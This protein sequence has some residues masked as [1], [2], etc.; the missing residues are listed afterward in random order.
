MKDTSN[1]PEIPDEL[2]KIVDNVLA[3]RPKPKRRRQRSASARKQRWRN[4]L[5]ND[6]RNKPIRM[7]RK[8]NF[9]GLLL[10]IG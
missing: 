3:Y 6:L 9:D 2:N 8:Y 10:P 7:N 4:K 5:G 1:I